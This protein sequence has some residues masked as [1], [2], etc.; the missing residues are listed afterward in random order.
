MGLFVPAGAKQIL[1]VY[2]PPSRVSRFLCT[3]GP[4]SG[5]ALEG[6]SAHSVRYYHSALS[7]LAR[8]AGGP[9]DSKPAI[10]NIRLVTVRIGVCLPVGPRNRVRYEVAKGRHPS[11]PRQIAWPVDNSWTVDRQMTPEEPQIRSSRAGALLMGVRYHIDKTNGAVFIVGEVCSMSKR[12]K[13]CKKSLA[14]SS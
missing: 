8:K 4:E 5:Q 1:C 6:E 7:G 2:N 13:G 10:P 14:R 11:R 3:A 9:P 12:S